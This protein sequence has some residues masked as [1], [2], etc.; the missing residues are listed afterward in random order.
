MF[1]LRSD[2]YILAALYST[3]C[4]TLYWYGFDWCYGHVCGN[5]IY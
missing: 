5:P 1:K 2:V 4:Y 3:L